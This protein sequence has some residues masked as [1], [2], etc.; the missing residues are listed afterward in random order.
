M[1][2]ENPR[3]QSPTRDEQ[4]DQRE[5]TVPEAAE[6]RAQ[7]ETDTQGQESPADQRRMQAM[8]KRLG[9][10]MTRGSKEPETQILK[11]PRRARGGKGDK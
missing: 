2:E 1:P 10:H 4:E 9:D 8:L 6:E 5:N 7:D 11:E 3:I